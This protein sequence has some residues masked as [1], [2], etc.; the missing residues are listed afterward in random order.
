M[1]PDPFNVTWRP[2]MTHNLSLCLSTLEKCCW[3]LLF[4]HHFWS[5]ISCLASPRTSLHPSFLPLPSSHLVP[6]FISLHNTHPAL[7]R[8]SSCHFTL[9][10]V[11]LYC[12]GVK[13]DDAVF[14]FAW[15]SCSSSSSSMQ[16][17]TST[18]WAYLVHRWTQFPE[19]YRY[20]HSNFKCPPCSFATGESA[21]E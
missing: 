20:K 4:R 3:V 10:P 16:L 18:W 11:T 13:R 8:H 12:L 19:T 17:V 5:R 7:R 2:P 6:G 14:P 21:G 15:H 1:L 9:L